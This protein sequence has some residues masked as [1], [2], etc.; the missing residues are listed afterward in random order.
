MFE[1]K[2]YRDVMFYDIEKWYKN[3]RRIDLLFQNWREEFDKF[4]PK[5]SKIW[6]I[7]ILMGSFWTKY[8]IFKLKKHRRVMFDTIED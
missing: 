6:N 5:H 3:W 4:W 8:L 1:L 7:C 2:K